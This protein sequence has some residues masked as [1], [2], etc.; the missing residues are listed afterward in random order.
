MYAFKVEAAFL[1]QQMLVLKIKWGKTVKYCCF[2]KMLQLL[3]LQQKG[4]CAFER[5]K[6]SKP[7]GNCLHPCSLCNG[8]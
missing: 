8:K 5:K 7:F 2:M 6:K 3:L 4:R 1:K